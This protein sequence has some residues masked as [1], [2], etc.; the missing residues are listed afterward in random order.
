VAETACAPGIS[1][2]PELRSGT[3]CTAFFPLAAPEMPENAD[4]PA[5]S[6]YMPAK[7][8]TARNVT[9]FLGE[10]KI[11]KES[12][13]LPITYYVVASFSAPQLLNLFHIVIPLRSGMEG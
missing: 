13:F 3:F 12:F 2:P 8:N 7:N 6:A 1:G 10:I 11:T 4:F 9:S 5:F